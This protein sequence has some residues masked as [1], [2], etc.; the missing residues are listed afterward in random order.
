[1][2]KNLGIK[3]APRSHHGHCFGGSNFTP[4]YRAWKAMI[5]RC[6]NPNC[7][8]YRNYGGRGIAVH[9]GFRSSFM[10]FL[11]EIGN[12]PSPGHS[13]DRIDNSKGYEPG[14]VRWA[15]RKEQ[16]RNLRRNVFIEFNGQRRCISAWAE[17]IGITT[18]CL[19]G[20]LKRGWSIERALGEPIQRK[21]A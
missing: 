15:T 5:E 11:N 20:R 6:E 12:R 8:H 7:K 14:N 21:A 3:K 2:S 13:L 18:S 9:T 19:N 10:A 1:M 4:E 16:N 17:A